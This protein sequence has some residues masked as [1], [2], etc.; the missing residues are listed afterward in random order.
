MDSHRM[1]NLA[2]IK[3]GATLMDTNS[4]ELDMV[5]G[6]LKHIPQTG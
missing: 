1:R 3:I 4:R 2:A 6:A 5:F